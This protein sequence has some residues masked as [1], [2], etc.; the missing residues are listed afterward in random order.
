M[1]T[2][3]HTET[4]LVSPEAFAHELALICTDV[5][6]SQHVDYMLKCWEKDDYNNN[7]RP[8]YLRK[9]AIRLCQDLNKTNRSDE[10]YDRLHQFYRSGVRPNG[11]KI[12]NPSNY[13]GN[14][15]SIGITPPRSSKETRHV[16]FEALIGDIIQHGFSMP[17]DHPNNL[18]GYNLVSKAMHAHFPSDQDQ[19]D[20]CLNWLVSGDFAT[21]DLSEQDL[22]SIMHTFY[23]E[24]CNHFGPVDADEYVTSALESVRRLPE[25]MSF[26]PKRFL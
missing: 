14:V 7:F 5:I 2:N 10:L 23:K 6:G 16:V 8:M 11:A 18:D 1:A 19:A 21:L 15:V 20:A 12:H 9:F 3:N 25:T 17:L 4:R 24:L 22:S 13:G 26:P